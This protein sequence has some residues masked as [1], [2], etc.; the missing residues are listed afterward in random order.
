[1]SSSDPRGNKR[2]GGAPVPPVSGCT[3]F[4]AGATVDCAPSPTART[5]DTLDG[6][7]MPDDG[8]IPPWA[9]LAENAESEFE[10]NMLSIIRRIS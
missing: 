7:L 4:G 6:A 1:M 9:R 5:R 2:L 10:D 3:S 8:L